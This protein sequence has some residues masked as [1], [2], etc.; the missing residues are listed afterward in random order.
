QG[1]MLQ[2]KQVESLIVPAAGAPTPPSLRPVQTARVTFTTTTRLDPDHLV[3]FPA[4]V[5]TVDV[6]RDPRDGSI[7]F[8]F[9]D[10][11]RGDQ[12]LA[13]YDT[14]LQPAALGQAIAGVRE[15]L[16]QMAIGYAR[17]RMGDEAHLQAWLPA[18]ARAGRYLY[19]ALLPENQGRAS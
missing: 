6:Q 11:S 12:E 17:I 13:Y 16:K 14:R 19:R 9:L 18:L 3:H 10:R 8:R 7:D 4:R 1:H 15:Q 5:L 2:S